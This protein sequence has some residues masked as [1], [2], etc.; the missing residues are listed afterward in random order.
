MSRYI[1]QY[2]CDG[3]VLELVRVHDNGTEEAGQA[4][5]VKR[6]LC[7]STTTITMGE[8]GPREELWIWLDHKGA[9]DEAPTLC[10]EGVTFDDLS[11]AMR[12][13]DSRRDRPKEQP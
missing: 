8:V 1:R 12:F 7:A 10:W 3:P 9:N 13:E 5:A 11:R 4:F 2:W 6:L